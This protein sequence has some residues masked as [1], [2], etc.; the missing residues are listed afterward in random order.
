MQI[1]F[2]AEELHSNKQE[3]LQNLKYS[4]LE[5]N[6]KITEFK[7]N[8]KN[9]IGQNRQKNIS[10]FLKKIERDYKKLTENDSISEII[11]TYDELKSLKILFLEKKRVRIYFNENKLK[12]S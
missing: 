10:D 2:N 5:L 6:S 3:E 12:R 11:D 4:L 8:K 1:D 9:F 7:K